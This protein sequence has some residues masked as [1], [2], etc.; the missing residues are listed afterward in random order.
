M[1]IKPG[2]ES[3]KIVDQVSKDSKL[4]NIRLDHDVELGYC[5]TVRPVI[6]SS[7]GESSCLG[8]VF[9]GI[10]S[11]EQSFSQLLPAIAADIPVSN[12]TGRSERILN[13]STHLYRITL[14]QEEIVPHQRFLCYGFRSLHI[15]SSIRCLTCASEV[16]HE[17]LTQPYR[18]CSKGSLKQFT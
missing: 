6:K 10:L 8:P 16:P 4:F 1:N 14:L 18:N 9:S 11:V 12:Y 17:A 2:N 15:G 13:N 7:L 3:D 5:N